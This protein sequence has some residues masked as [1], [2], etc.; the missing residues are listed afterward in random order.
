MEWVVLMESYVASGA[1][2]KND[3]SYAALSVSLSLS[4]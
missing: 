1:G 3:I 2:K 4:N